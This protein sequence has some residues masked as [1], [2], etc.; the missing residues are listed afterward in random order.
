MRYIFTVL[1]ICFLS[2]LAF[3]Q[4]PAQYTTYMLDP[5]RYNPAYAGLDYALSV[6]GT[7]RQQWAGLTGA[8]RGQRLSA[9]LPLYFLRGGFG[10]Q[11]ENDAI[12]A[13]QLTIARADYNYQLEMGSGV[14]SAGL[15]VSMQ[16]WT[17]NG[18]ELL[19]PNGIYEGPGSPDHQDNILNQ[20][21][22]SASG[23]QFTAGVFY[24]TEKLEA[25]LSVENLSST[26][27][28]LNQFDYQVLRAYHAFIRANFEVGNSLLVQPS[29]WLRTDEIE[30]QV[31]LSVLVTY[32]DNI[33]GGVSFRGYDAARQDALAIIAGF[34]LAPSIQLAYAYDIALSP[35]QSVHSGSHEIV[36]KYRLD[37]AI[38]K[39]KLPPIIYHPR[40]K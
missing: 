25:G 14:L 20:A 21:T 35:L 16:Q 22:E 30:N 39:G 26:S 27:L 28:Q 17:L 5:L 4:Q 32:N 15:G 18:N 23:L 31:D 8:P 29:V 2:H 33:F 6:T 10:L 1:S 7:F 19:S 12:G 9:H 38:G 11:L 24:Q 13:H 36:V 37:K 3:A 34:Q 40:A